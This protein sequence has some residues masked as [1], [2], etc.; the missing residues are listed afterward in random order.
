MIFSETAHNI[1]RY[2]DI[3]RL[4]WKYG[5]SD[6]I[7]SIEAERLVDQEIALDDDTAAKAKELPDDLE[8]LGPTY[9]KF[10]QFLSTR[11]D[12]L[13]EPYLEALQRLQDNVEPIPFE[14][15]EKIIT[16]ELGARI[17]KIFVEFDEKPL[18][19]ASLGQTHRAVM[20]N[21]RIVV[22]KVQRPDIRMQVAEDLEAFE[23]IARLAEEK[24]VMGKRYM[25]HS[26][27]VEFRRAMLRELD[28]RK[29]AENLLT[30]EENLREFENIL[31]PRPVEG[32]TTSRV[33]TM[34][35][36]E[37]AKITSISPLRTLG[38]DGEAL[39]DELLKSYLKQI[40]VDGFYHAD[41]HP[42]NVFLTTLNQIALLDLG[43]VA[44][45]P[46]DKRPDLLRM[47]IAIS[48]GDGGKAAQAIVRLG[49]TSEEYNEDGLRSEITSFLTNSRNSR[50][51]SIQTG[52]MVLGLTAMA[53][54]N[55]V[56]LP[57]EFVMIGKTLMNLDRV[58]MALSKNFS[59]NDSI[60]RHLLELMQRERA[61]ELSFAS[62]YD[63]L[64][65][66]KEFMETLP[67]R[68]NRILG[69]I[70]DDK[71]TLRAKV[72]DEKYL[73]VG[74]QKIANRL[75]VGLVL[76]AI[77]VGAALMMRVETSFRIFGYPGLAIVFF[78]LAAVIGFTLIY[79][80]MF[81]DERTKKKGEEWS[82]T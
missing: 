65:S 64:V 57:N 11:S 47:L 59:P 35:F 51:E 73:M 15:I 26:M 49:R 66:T 38:I 31:V 53:A 30:L 24:T 1:K 16:E 14:T 44:T 34:E 71:F 10:G 72:I 27:V 19:A 40:V 12:L 67:D 58:G 48:E 39:A 52:R 62:V 6:V 9:V 76:A 21:G 56:R 23:E 45:I 78:L 20:R 25:L 50:M 3:A 82:R 32:L 42:G 13:P 33:L 77:I 68:A 74:L 41:P 43:M 18:A 63:T 69:A 70:A 81:S 79:R 55:G 17:S 60:R 46:S 8:K 36:V 22:V 29:E 61:E 4:V 2:T 5:G 80:I 37:G 75:T 28:Y 54:D 7:R